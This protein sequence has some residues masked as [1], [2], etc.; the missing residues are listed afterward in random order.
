MHSINNP[1]PSTYYV[2]GTVLGPGSEQNRPNPVL[3]ELAFLGIT[4]M[5]SKGACCPSLQSILLEMRTASFLAQIQQVNIKSLS[6]LRE[7]KKEPT[8]RSL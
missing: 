8:Q 1:T 4:L 6:K 2:P 5:P 7:K 3:G